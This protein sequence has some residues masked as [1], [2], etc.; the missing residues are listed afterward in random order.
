M[1]AQNNVEWL[2]HHTE[3]YWYNMND[4]CEAM[5]DFE[6]VEKLGWG[7]SSA[8]PL[9]AIDIGD[10]ITPR[11]TFVNKNMSLDYK[12]AIITLLKE[13]ANCFA[14]NYHKMSKLSRELVEH[15]LP[16]KFGFRPYKHLAWKFNLV[17]HDRVM[18]E[19]SR[20]LDAGFIRPC[21][22]T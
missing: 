18:D 7:F 15:Q 11:A 19:V 20:L 21:Q 13:Y 17:N 16:I 5:E 22:Y 6:V 9:E 4:M 1:S 14:R 12:D 10:W 8:D 3:Q 2:R